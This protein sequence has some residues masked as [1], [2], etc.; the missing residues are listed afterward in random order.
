MP[1]KNRFIA[2]AAGVIIKHPLLSLVDINGEPA[3]I[4][5]ITLIDQKENPIDNYQIKILCGQFPHK[6][7]LVFETGGKIPK[8]IDWHMY[9]QTGNCCLCIPPEE[10]KLCNMGFS[11]VSFMD[12]FVLPYFFHQTYRRKN[13]FFRD[14]WQHGIA[15]LYAYYSDLFATTNIFEIIRLLEKIVAGGPPHRNSPCLCGSG[16]KYRHCHKER[17]KSVFIENRAEITS[18][19]SLLKQFAVMAALAMPII[20]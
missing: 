4:G 9:E 16:Q 3:L 19:I 15:G 17:V 13:G 11:L 5:T 18:D 12:D 6:F 1:D 2:E 8:N 20:A 10:R 7:P 14:E